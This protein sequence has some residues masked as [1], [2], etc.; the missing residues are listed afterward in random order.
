MNNL[1]MLY[2]SLDRKEDARLY[3]KKA[4]KLLGDSLGKSHPNTRAV[5]RNLQTMKTT[6]PVRAVKIPRK[7]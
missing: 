6:S 3:F 1:A 4:L 5:K 7:A 2:A